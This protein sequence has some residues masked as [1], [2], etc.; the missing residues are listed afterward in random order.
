MCE[1]LLVCFGFIIHIFDG[2]DDDDIRF[3]E[4]T[5]LQA[6]Y[7]VQHILIQLAEIQGTVLE[8]WTDYPIPKAVVTV[9]ETG[10]VA[11]TDGRGKFHLNSVEQGLVHLVGTADQHS[12][13]MTMVEVDDPLGVYPVKLYLKPIARIL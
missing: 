9:R 1:S 4:E 13:H 5:K 12:S 2:G 11:T 6:F 3:A 10:E 8:Q 7:L